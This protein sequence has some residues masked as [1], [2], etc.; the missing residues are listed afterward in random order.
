MAHINHLD[1]Y[2]ESF[3][4]DNDIYFLKNT[5]MKKIE[6]QDLKHALIHWRYLSEN[7]QPIDL[8]QKNIDKKL[9]YINVLEENILRHLNRAR[10][11]LYAD[12]GE[13]KSI[14]FK[15]NR[16]KERLEVR[17]INET[18]VETS[19]LDRLNSMP[20]EIVR[21]ISEFAFTPKLRLQLILHRLPLYN[22]LLEKL[23][24]PKLK[25]LSRT[26]ADQLDKLSVKINKNSSIIKY[27]NCFQR[28]TKIWD[29]YNKIVNIKRNIRE[30]MKKSDK[31]N[32]IMTNLKSCH[33]LIEA[34]DKL[35]FIKT[36]D[37]LRTIFIETL[38]TFVMAINPES[39]RRV[40]QTA[41]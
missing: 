21:Y 32:E 27:L 31:I 18:A 33:T 20:E 13:V 30:G 2:N 24:L 4:D 15:K 29:T 37:C 5:L 41:Q 11:K 22:I 16:D 36:A 3:F 39:N 17:N 19:I 9:T 10:N 6:T 7:T 23:K 8:I 12:L 35:A 1:L 34:V 38:C 40:R 14:I 25:R 26:L 28:K